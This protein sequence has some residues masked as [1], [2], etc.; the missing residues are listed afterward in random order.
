MKSNKVKGFTFK[1]ANKQQKQT[2]AKARDGVAIAGC[3]RYTTQ[4]GFQDWKNTNP[5]NH[6]KDEGFIC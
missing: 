6:Q 1:V 4:W 5:F 3:T 2:E